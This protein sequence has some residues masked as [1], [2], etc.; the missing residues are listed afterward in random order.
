[1]AKK[2]KDADNLV[3][4]W[5]LKIGPLTFFV[6]WQSEEL[7]VANEEWGSCHFE[8]GV[9]RLQE[10]MEGV[11]FLTILF[12]EILHAIHYV[13]GLDDTSSE[14]SFTHGTAMGLVEFALENPEAWDW[15]VAEMKALQVT[16]AVLTEKAAKKAK[17]GKRR[18]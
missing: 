15:L 2:T 11:F 5:P 4:P 3:M 10:G 16:P 7:A 14:E 17:R 12:H 13:R 9:I 6:E 8:K 1:M 18:G